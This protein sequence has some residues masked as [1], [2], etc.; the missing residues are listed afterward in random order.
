MTKKLSPGGR[1][2]NWKPDLPDHRDHVYLSSP[3][4]RL[5]TSVDLRDKMRPVKNQ[6]SLGSCTGHAIGSYVDFLN[7]GEPNASRLFIY[8]NERLLEGTVKED[9]GATIRSGI[10]AVAKF[11]ACKETL[12]P[13]KIANFDNEP[14]EHAYEH[15]KQNRIV[16]YQRVKNLH[17]LK[18]S[19]VEGHPVVFGMA[20]YES[21][22]SE[23]VTNTG[24]VPMPKK[25]EACLGGHAVLAVGY[26]DVTKRVIVRNSWG[27]G[28]GDE[29]YFTL[30]Y[31]YI[32]NTDLCD[33]FWTIRR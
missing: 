11:G 25:D 30:P 2:L 26:D 18:A 9:A 20:L 21:F 15:A 31:A 33:D 3:R 6:G 28:W 12:H 5:P 32:S 7:P 23:H 16:S 8:Y 17:G 24:T 1:R 22:E 19:L 14:S 13:Y 10:K 29:G 4:Q 27:K